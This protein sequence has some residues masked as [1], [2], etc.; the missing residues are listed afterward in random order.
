V[1]RLS[2]ANLPATSA[3]T[4]K[5]TRIQ[6][7]HGN[8]EW[9]QG[10]VPPKSQGPTSTYRKRREIIVIV[11]SE[12][13]STILDET[14]DPSGLSDLF[15]R[16]SRRKVSPKRCGSLLFY[17][18]ATAAGLAASRIFCQQNRSERSRTQSGP[19]VDEGCVSKEQGPPHQPVDR[20]DTSYERCLSVACPWATVTSSRLARSNRSGYR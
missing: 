15:T 10:V 14:R 18:S 12:T 9:A 17:S 8:E 11:S 2:E 13:V 7:A 3:Q 16:Y 6:G 1:E 5:Q 19:A 4:D 20:G